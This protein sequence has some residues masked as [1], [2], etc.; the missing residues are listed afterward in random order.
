MPSVNSWSRRYLITLAVCKVPIETMPRH[1]ARLKNLR[2]FFA[3]ASDFRSMGGPADA[4]PRF[5]EGRK[6]ELADK[7]S[8]EGVSA[9]SSFAGFSSRSVRDF[10]VLLF[11][12]TGNTKSAG[13]LN[14]T[15]SI[16]R[17]TLLQGEFRIN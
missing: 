17:F 4:G 14:Q 8:R 7:S 6:I 13:E 12:H 3:H 16:N 2:S 1:Y 9:G 11:S 5:L 15:M 10:H